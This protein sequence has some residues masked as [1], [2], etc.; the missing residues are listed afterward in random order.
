LISARQTP[1]T[2]FVPMH[3]TDQFASRAR[4]GRLVPAL[5]DPTSGQPA[6]KRVPARIERFEAAV[7]GFAVLRTKP[8]DIEA[9]YWAAAKCEGGWR[10]ELAFAEDRQDWSAVAAKLFSPPTGAETIAYGDLHAGLNR[11]A[12]F[13]GESLIGALYLAREPVAVSRTWAVEQL[14]IPCAKRRARLAV[15]A[16]RPG[17]G[18]IDRGPTVCACFGVG[19][20]EI[21]ASVARG[22]RTVAAVGEAL[23]AGTNCGSC[24]AEIRGIIEANLLEAAE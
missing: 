5:T 24:R 3:W 22:C 11:F 23:G 15:M 21:A 8:T 4:V 7:Y 6:L 16:G 12:C 18:A 9:E 13:D 17:K 2:L 14:G 20:Q 10:L 19:A 1:G